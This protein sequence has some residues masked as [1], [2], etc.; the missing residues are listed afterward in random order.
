MV[1][2]TV[3]KIWIWK[4]GFCDKSIYET[5]STRQWHGRTHRTIDASLQMKKVTI[6]FF[7]SSLKSQFNRFRS[8]IAI[9]YFLFRF[10]RFF[11]RRFQFTCFVLFFKVWIQL[12]S[13]KKRIVGVSKSLKMGKKRVMLPAKDVDLSSIKYEREVVQGNLTGLFCNQAEFAVS[14][15]NIW[16]HFLSFFLLFVYLFLAAPHLTGFVFRL[17]VRILELP[18]IGPIIIN[19]LKKQNKIDQVC[20]L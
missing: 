9:S 8:A 5:T 14:D 3:R 18:L 15:T 17:F 13:W 4:R 11:S 2:P 1:S 19:V 6:T 10:R 20:V 16:F 7:T 12:R